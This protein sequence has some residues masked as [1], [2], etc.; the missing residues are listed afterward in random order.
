MSHCPTGYETLCHTFWQMRKQEYL[1][2]SLKAKSPFRKYNTY[3]CTRTHIHTHM[4]NA[5]SP[6][7]P[8]FTVSHGDMFIHTLIYGHIC[9]SALITHT[10]NVYMNIVTHMSYTYT[11]KH[12]ASHTWRIY[13]Q[14]H[15][16]WTQLLIHTKS[17]QFT[18]SHTPTH[19]LSYT[20]THTHRETH[21]HIFSHTHTHTF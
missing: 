1:S 15:I 11:H 12:I 6:H 14:I 4:C 5:V 17:H 10:Q 21:S 3:M 13:R 9:T 18:Y 20:H 8:I 19:I 7:T 16:H 2:M